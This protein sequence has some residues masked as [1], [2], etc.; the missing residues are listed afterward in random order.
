MIDGVRDE[1]GRQ[2]PEDGLDLKAGL[3]IATVE[4]ELRE[5]TGTAQT[6]L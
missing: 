2:V 6:M 5:H 1:I 3:R 4:V